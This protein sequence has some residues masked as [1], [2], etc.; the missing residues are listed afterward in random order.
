[1]NDTSTIE[2]SAAIELLSFRAGGQ[3]Y[4]ID[5]GST[6]EIRSWTIP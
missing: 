5:I 1:M 3:D 4:A 6:R 2:K